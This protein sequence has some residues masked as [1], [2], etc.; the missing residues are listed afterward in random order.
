MHIDSTQV[1]PNEF[2]AFLLEAKRVLHV[3]HLW[4]VRVYLQVGWRWELVSHT[5]ALQSV[6]VANLCDALFSKVL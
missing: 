3:A 1:F 2:N 5:F 6:F 4:Y